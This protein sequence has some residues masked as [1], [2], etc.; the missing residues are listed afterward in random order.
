[1]LATVMRL[2]VQVLLLLGGVAGS[3]VLSCEVEICDQPEPCFQA[4]V[5]PKERLGK[6]LAKEQVLALKL[7]RLR[8]LSQ[9]VSGYC[10]GQ[11]RWLLS[12]VL[13]IEPNPAAAI[14]FFG[15]H[16]RICRCWMITSVCGLLKHT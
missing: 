8:G 9:R 15:V 12:G 4:A 13:S 3:A 14:P 7:E 6:A 2:C 5:L 1:M 16:N 10:L 11:T